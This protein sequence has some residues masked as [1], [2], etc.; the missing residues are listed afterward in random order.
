MKMTFEKFQ[1][2]AKKALVNM[3]SIINSA[4]VKVLKKL[5][6]CVQDNL[7]KQYALIITENGAVEDAETRLFPDIQSAREA[8]LKEFFDAG[9]SKDELEEIQT[10]FD[11]KL[12]CEK[13]RG[14]IDGYE[15]GLEGNMAWYESCGCEIRLYIQPVYTWNGKMADAE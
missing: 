14:K 11:E 9:F 3:P 5:L 15:C 6:S 1:T 8:L 10:S 7:Q 2:E 12:P 13:G 4:E